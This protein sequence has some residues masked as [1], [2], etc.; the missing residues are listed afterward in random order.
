MGL[1]II[2][3]LVSTARNFLWSISNARD[4]CECWLWSSEMNEAGHH[5]WLWEPLW[6]VDLGGTW[7]T[8]H[9]GRQ[10]AWWV[11]G[12]DGWLALKPGLAVAE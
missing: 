4:V 2:Y 10:E 12:E 9:S 6:T 8:V 7:S 5:N 3:L 11:L 1:R